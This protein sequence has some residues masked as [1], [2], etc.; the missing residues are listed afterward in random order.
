[1][2]PSHERVVPTSLQFPVRSVSFGAP[3]ACAGSPSGP[4]LVPVRRRLVGRLE[5]GAGRGVVGVPFDR[6]GARSDLGGD[7]AWIGDAGAR[8]AAARRRERPGR[9]GRDLA[10]VVPAVVLLVR[11]LVPPEIDSVRHL[12]A[13]R[14]D[15]HHVVVEAVPVGGRLHGCARLLREGVGHRDQHRPATPV[16]VDPV[17]GD[18]VVVAAGDQDAHAHRHRHARIDVGAPAGRC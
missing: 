13:V 2:K 15:P 5:P 8:V 6:G 7:L 3:D 11:R 9:V 4:P 10:V 1:M 16:V 17:A 18:V 12:R 14:G